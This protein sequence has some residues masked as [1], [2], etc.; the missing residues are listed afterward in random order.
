MFDNLKG[1]TTRIIDDMLRR[2]GVTDYI[3]IDQCSIISD[4]RIV[5]LMAEQS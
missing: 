1:K 5:E 2:T 3:T 4:P